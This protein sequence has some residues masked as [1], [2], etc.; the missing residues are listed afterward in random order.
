MFNIVAGSHFT[1]CVLVVFTPDGLM[2]SINNGTLSCPIALEIPIYGHQV[3]SFL[4][5]N[6]AFTP[7]LFPHVP[8]P[9]DKSIKVVWPILPVSFTP[10]TPQL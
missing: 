7:I 3:F 8:T 4:A 6:M 5:L 10:I 1:L 9:A 2:V